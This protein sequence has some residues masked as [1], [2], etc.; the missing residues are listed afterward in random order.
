MII[1]ISLCAVFAVGYF[2]GQSMGRLSVQS[3]KEREYL[4][5]QAILSHNAKKLLTSKTNSDI[6]NRAQTY[7]R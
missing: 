2:I 7:S 4:D 3:D 1:L 5:C 6:L